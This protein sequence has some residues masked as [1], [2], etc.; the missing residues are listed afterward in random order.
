MRESL[1]NTPT[2]DKKFIDRV[3]GEEKVMKDIIEQFT[4]KT[5]K[6]KE[7]ENRKWLIDI[8]NSWG[9]LAAFLLIAYIILRF[10]ES[11]VRFVFFH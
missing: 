5:L 1:D 4:E 2:V 9:F 10:I 3:E 8:L 7:L 6:L 11:F